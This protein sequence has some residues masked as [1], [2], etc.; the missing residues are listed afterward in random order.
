MTAVQIA[1]HSKVNLKTVRAW[2]KREEASDRYSE[3]LSLLT[4][5]A[6]KT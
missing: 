3:F 4:T 1:K 2:S 6:R 5:S